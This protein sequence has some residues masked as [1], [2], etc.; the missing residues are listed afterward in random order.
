MLFGGKSADL[1]F[2]CDRGGCSCPIAFVPKK[3]G[4]RV[5]R[6]P[7]G[8]VLYRAVQAAWGTFVGSVEAG[9]RSVP[10]FCLREVEAFLRCGVLSQGFAR[11]P[12]M[13]AVLTT[14]WSFRA[15]VVGGALRTVRWACLFGC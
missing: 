3:E 2:G 1:P 11:V 5:R 7:E 4:G 9:E 12:A 8:T 14:W 15:R 10:R 13:A 6:E